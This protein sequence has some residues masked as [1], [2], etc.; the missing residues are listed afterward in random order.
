MLYSFVENGCRLVICLNRLL[1]VRVTFVENYRKGKKIASQKL[2][3]KAKNG[4]PKKVG[5]T[6]AYYELFCLSTFIYLFILFV[7]FFGYSLLAAD[8]RASHS[9]RNCIIYLA[10]KSYRIEF[11]FS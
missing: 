1:I 2:Y 5:I 10:L 6:N 9:L 11:Q 4:L 3:T 7:F 8:H